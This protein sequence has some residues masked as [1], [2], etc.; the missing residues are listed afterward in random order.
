MENRVNYWELEFTD[1]YDGIIFRPMKLDPIEFVNLVTMH[2]AQ[3]NASMDKQKEFIS[4]CLKHIQWTKD[5]NTWNPLL[6]ANGSARLPEL[7]THPEIG[8]DVYFEYVKEVI[9]PVFI[10]SKTFRNLMSE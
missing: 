9:S 6:N 8:F 1:I 10:E 3:V 4:G 7:E 2:T 5:G